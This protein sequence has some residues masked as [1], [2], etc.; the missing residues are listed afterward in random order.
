MERMEEEL[1]ANLVGFESR[2]ASVEDG[3]ATK[4]DANTNDACI[5]ST[6]DFKDWNG[7]H[8]PTNAV[9][10]QTQ[11][12]QGSGSGWRA[13]AEIYG[14]LRPCGP[15]SPLSA[16]ARQISAAGVTDRWAVVSSSLADVGAGGMQHDALLLDSPARLG[17]ITS[18]TDWASALTATSAAANRRLAPLPLAL[19]PLLRRKKPVEGGPANHVDRAAS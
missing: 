6:S 4:I 7:G 18:N 8:W 17:I 13:E 12:G 11:P 10:N 2:L 3:F 5:A 19:R 1:L 15:E 16:E 9:L 14:T